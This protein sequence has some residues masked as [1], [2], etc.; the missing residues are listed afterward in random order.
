MSEAQTPPDPNLMAAVQTCNEMMQQK[1]MTHA[2]LIV[3]QREL[4]DVRAEMD[5]LRDR[6]TNA[7]VEALRG[8][9]P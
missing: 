5:A 9:A 6:L 4:A 3:A 8:G 1:I 7:E 2:A